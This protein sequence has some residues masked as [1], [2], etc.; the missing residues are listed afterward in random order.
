MVLMIWWLV[1]AALTGFLSVCQQAPSLCFLS[2]S[3]SLAPLRLFY[4][5]LSV[6]CALAAAEVTFSLFC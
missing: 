1:A 5:L 3:L 2:A 4:I 6:F